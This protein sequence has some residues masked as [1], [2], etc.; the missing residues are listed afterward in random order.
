MTCSN[1]LASAAL[2]NDA[3]TFF[4]TTQ[5]DAEKALALI[6]EQLASHSSPA[7]LKQDLLDLQAQIK[8]AK[9][10]LTAIKSG[11]ADDKAMETVSGLLVAV[12]NWLALVA[13]TPAP[14]QA[15]FGKFVA[16]LA[17]SKVVLTGLLE[18]VSPILS[19]ALEGPTF[20]VKDL[21]KV[22]REET[23]KYILYKVYRTIKFFPRFKNGERI[24]YKHV[25][26]NQRELFA[27]GDEYKDFPVTPV[28]AYKTAQKV[29]KRLSEKDYSGELDELIENVEGFWV[30]WRIP[31]GKPINI[32]IGGEIKTLQPG[33]TYTQRSIIEFKG[34]KY[35]EVDNH[36][37]FLYEELRF[38]GAAIKYNPKV[39]VDI[40][41]YVLMG[42]NEDWNDTVTGT[43]MTYGELAIKRAEVIKKQLIKLLKQWN[44]VFDEKRI[45]AG[46]G[47]SKANQG[48]TVEFIIKNN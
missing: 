19:N 46:R 32:E 7:N 17:G 45:T 33:E 35:D 39:S 43:D 14:V 22:T 34:R 9:P 31:K 8:T 16:Q 5:S 15:A 40:R 4:E 13:M 11:T 25:Y 44:I 2:D 42:V 36:N 26:Q 37:Q 27:D 24:A 41:G 1:Y 48:Q 18:Q 30:E 28:D 10:L 20:S 3:K 6:N 12:D 23:D 21:E 29:A 38:V 47:L